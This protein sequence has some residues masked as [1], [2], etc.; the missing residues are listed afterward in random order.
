MTQLDGGG[1]GK[2]FQAGWN[3]AAA[4]PCDYCNSAAALLFCRAESAFLCMSCDA[5]LHSADDKPAAAL[6]H[7]RVWMCD[8][9]QQAPAAVTCKADAAALCVTCDRGIHSANPLARR[10]ERAAVVPFYDTAESMVTKSN[11]T[12]AV[13][14]GGDYHRKLDT[15]TTLNDYFPDSWISSGE[16][17]ITTKLP[18]DNPAMGFFFSDSD[19][20][21][22]LDNY[23]IFSSNPFNDSVV[24]VQTTVK[25]PVQAQLIHK[26]S[27]ENRFEIDFTRS[28]ITSYTNQKKFQA[29][30]SSTDVGIVPDVSSGGV[31]ETTS[32]PFATTSV[33]SENYDPIP[34]RSINHVDRKARVLR[35]KEKRKNRKFEK[36]IRYASRKAYAETR[37]RIKGRFA[38]RTEY[39]SDADELFSSG[40]GN[41]FA[42]GGYGVVP[43]F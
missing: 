43:S 27:P 23:Q 16:P 11:P 1:G 9:C 40:A 42:D 34:I 20:F 36:T 32:Y 2:C 6:R 28:N 19:Q 35:Y 13:L 7:E 14:L 37:P 8:V 10:H 39:D 33:K 26:Q 31:S 3:V 22:D 25:P 12:A 5:K 24:P 17:F 30:S 18:A 29:T 38:K 15:P 41:F 21:L 4:K